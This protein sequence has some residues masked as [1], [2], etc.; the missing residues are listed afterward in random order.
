MSSFF[1]SFSKGLQLAVLGAWAVTPS[2]GQVEPCIDESL[3]DPNAVCITLYS[4]VCGCDGVTYDNSCLAQVVAGVTSWSEGPC[5]AEPCQDLAG[6]DF[7]ECDM[8]LGVAQIN[9]VCTTVSGCDWVVNGVDYSPAFFEDEPT[10]TMCNEVPPECGLQLLVATEDGMWYDFTALDVPSDAVL[11]WYIDDFLAQTGGTSFQAG[12]DF[13]PNW[14]VCVQYTSAPC[15]GAVQQCYSNLDGVAPCTDL[16]GVDLGLCELAL[17]V[18]RVNGTC[19]YISGCDTYA[20]GI[21]YAGALF[22]SMEDC[23]LGCA[24]TCVDAQLLELGAMVDCTTEYA[25]VCGC[26]GITYGNVCEAM[27]GGGV[28][29]WTE[30]PCGNGGGV[31]LGCTYS[32]ACNFNPD[33]NDDDGSCVF[34]PDSCAWPIPSGCTYTMAFNYNPDAL[35]DDGSCTFN[36]VTPCWGDLNGDGTVSVT[37][38]LEIL[39]LFGSVC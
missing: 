22:E 29:S 23:I 18:G 36:L 15:G 39:A 14:S 38:I 3:I 33:A 16:A 4:P 20:G 10:C 37:D 17:G 12:F 13:N 9:G 24:E 8:V 28:T 19:Q 34:A 5:S 2:L 35:V 6:V 27:Y 25:P 30:G 7:G 21:N 31:V 1:S 11:E 26:N 32:V